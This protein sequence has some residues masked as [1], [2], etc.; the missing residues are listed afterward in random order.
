[1]DA[2]TIQL[3]KRIQGELG[4]L[5]GFLCAQFVQ[6]NS[7]KP[8]I[9][10][11]EFFQLNGWSIFNG[12]SIHFL[13]EVITDAGLISPSNSENLF[14]TSSTHCQGII[15][16]L[17]HTQVHAMTCIFHI[18]ECF[19]LWP[20][21]IPTIISKCMV[22]SLIVLTLHLLHKNINGIL[23]FHFT[24]MGLERKLPGTQQKCWRTLQPQ[25]IGQ[26][27]CRS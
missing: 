15:I 9:V 16:Y 13:K 4:R 17:I 24:E 25:T 3:N 12:S 5:T 7:I 8:S 26:G 20:A 2:P 18:W 6:K 1:M 11:Q 19:Y 27:D 10:H 23:T 21:Y 14:S 22:E